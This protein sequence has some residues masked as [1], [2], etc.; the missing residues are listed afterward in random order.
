MTTR[1]E[2]KAAGLSLYDTGKPCVQG[3]LSLRKTVT[4]Q[5]LECIKANSAAY[6]KRNPDKV[7][8]TN[9]A[10][11]GYHKTYSA[12]W[13]VHNKAAVNA[14]NKAWRELNAELNQRAN[15]AWKTQ[16]KDKVAGYR[17]KRRAAEHQAIPPWADFAKISEVYREA[18]LLRRVGLD[19]HVD[20]IVPLLGDAVCGLHVHNN[21]R[22]I[23]ASENLSKGNKHDTQRDQGLDALPYARG[24]DR[25]GRHHHR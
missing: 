13:Y 17:A 15:A 19:V 9:A 7:A 23:L 21:L 8:A 25:T 5:C 2:A 3:H 18:A 1:A 6:K 20:H 4:A 22:V 10:L 16:N 11:K 24:A 12:G 14:R